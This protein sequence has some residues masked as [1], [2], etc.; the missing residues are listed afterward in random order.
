MLG[1]GE[2]SEEEKKAVSELHGVGANALKIIE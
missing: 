1:R 2:M